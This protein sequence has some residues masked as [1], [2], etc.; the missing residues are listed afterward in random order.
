[1]FQVSDGLGFPTIWQLG[2]P[3]EP[4][5]KCTD[6]SRS[7]SGVT[8]HCCR[9]IPSGEAVAEACPCSRVGKWALLPDGG[10]VKFRKSLWEQKY[11]CGYF[12]RK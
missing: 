7:T 11:C 6:S 3:G 8:Q 5:R 4:D 9:H 10:G 2:S 1:M 12:L